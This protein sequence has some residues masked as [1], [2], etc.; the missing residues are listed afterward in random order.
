MHP[1]VSCF[2][3]I[4][5]IVSAAAAPASAADSVYFALGERHDLKSETLGR[6]ITLLVRE[7]EQ[8]DAKRLMPVLYVVGSDWRS[9]FAHMVST[10]ELLEAADHIPQMLVVGVDLPDGNGGLIPCPD[11]G[12]GAQADKWLQLLT[13]ELFPNGE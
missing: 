6:Q 10:V 9:R 11:R 1:V 3:T 13:D 7:P 12:D 4:V 2:A 5:L 8:D